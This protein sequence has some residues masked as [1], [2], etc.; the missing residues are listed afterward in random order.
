MGL[1]AWNKARQEEATDGDGN[2][3]EL[4]LR[5]KKKVAAETRLAEAR[6]KAKERRLR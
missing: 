6:R 4:R 5:R 1:S 3:R 2:K